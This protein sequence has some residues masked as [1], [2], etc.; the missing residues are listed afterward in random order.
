MRLWGRGWGWV[1][2]ERERTFEP[3][4]LLDQLVHSGGH[5]LDGG[6]VIGEPNVSM[7]QVTASPRRPSTSQH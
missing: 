5:D 1:H 3:D 2:V 4:A 7:P 6:R